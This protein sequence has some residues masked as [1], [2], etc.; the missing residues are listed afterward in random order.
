MNID[1]FE[2]RRIKAGE[3]TLHAVIGGTGSPLVLIHGFP[4]TWWEWRHVMPQL[5]EHH[6][7]I[8]VDLRGAGHSDK[9]QGG[10]DKRTLAADVH[11]VMSALGYEKYAVCGHDIGGMTALA[12]ALTHR[13][14]VTHLA[15]LDA[16]QPG[17]SGWEANSHKEKVWHFAF[18]MQRD[19]PE[20]LI[21]GRE[22]EYVSA[23]IYDRA[24]D[25]GAHPAADID[26]FAQSLA[27]PG[28][29]RGGLEWYRTFP[30]DHENAK[31]WKQDPLTI[32]VLALGGEH[33]YGARMVPMLE[34]F[35]VE[36]SGGSISGCGHWLAEE[37]PNE[38]TERLL[39]FLSR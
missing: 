2:H 18:H 33:S 1:N 20:M 29:L 21:Q 31:R 3:V 9:P 15:V 27:Q 11:A 26:T 19:L 30:Q 6:T 13:D 4:Q 10:Y 36:V 32:P 24:Y 34:E 37:H 5:A 25:V 35:A 39:E 7:V 38:L 22:R 23:F 14:A 12:L 8:A 16:S 17:W 28:N